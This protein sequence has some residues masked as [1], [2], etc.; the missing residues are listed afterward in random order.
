MSHKVKIE[1]ETT[2]NSSV[3][4]KAEKQYRANI[5]EIHCSYCPYHKNENITKR[6]KRVKKPKTYKDFN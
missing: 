4:R 2:T 6:Y 1:M 5:G 3:F